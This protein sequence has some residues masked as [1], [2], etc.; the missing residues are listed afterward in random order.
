ML[1][2][3]PPSLLGGLLLAG[4]LVATLPAAAQKVRIECLSF[5]KHSSE[6]IE[7]LI[8]PE[9]VVDVTLQSHALSDPLVVPSL[10][11]WKFGKSQVSDEGVFT[12]KTYGEVK[13]LSAARQLLVFIRKGKDAAAGFNILPLDA[14]KAGF[15]ANKMFIMNLARSR[16]AG[17]VGG[18]RFILTPGRHIIF[19]PAA[20]RGEN[21][22]FA[23]LRFERDKEWRTFFSTN[24]PILKNSRGLVFVFDDPRS[25]SLKIH[26]VVDSLFEAPK[27]G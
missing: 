2:R 16:V 27:P 25:K 22:C 24:W 23:A 7:L 1:L 19:K 4:G 10:P 20:N 9:K 8:G 13:P 11:V 6:S 5:P 21:L 12:F 15:G 3:F 17:D 26:S 14:N 18:K